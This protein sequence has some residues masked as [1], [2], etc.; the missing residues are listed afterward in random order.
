[1]NNLV[2]L[3]GPEKVLKHGWSNFAE[4]N[5][6]EAKEALTEGIHLELQDTFVELELFIRSQESYLG[7]DEELEDEG[8]LNCSSKPRLILKHALWDMAE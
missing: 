3:T 8:L 7:N 4:E 5:T 6:H 1:M 2:E